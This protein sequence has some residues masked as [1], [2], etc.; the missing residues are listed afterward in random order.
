[1]IYNLDMLTEKYKDAPFFFAFQNIG[2]LP[3]ADEDEQIRVATEWFEKY[4]DRKVF[5][6]FMD[7]TPLVMNT[8]YR[9]SREYYAD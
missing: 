8:I 1:M 3:G 7:A 9:L 6:S 5:S 2:L 4:K